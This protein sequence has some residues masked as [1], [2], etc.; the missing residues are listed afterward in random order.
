MLSAV[1]HMSKWRIEIIEEAADVLAIQSELIRIKTTAGAL[2][3]VVV[4]Y[5]QL[6]EGLRSKG[7]NREREVASISRTLKV[8]ATKLNCLVILLS[9]LN[10]D[11]RLRESRALGQ[12]ANAVLFLEQDG[13]KGMRVR[14][15]KA[16]SAPSGVEVPLQWLPQFTRFQ[17]RD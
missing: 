2:D 3:L 14:V 12:D 15:G 4:D 1:N 7:D 6:V 10:D 13:D 9:Q 8:A 11:G 17:A 16:R 5:A